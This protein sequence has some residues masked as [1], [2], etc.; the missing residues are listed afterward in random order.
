MLLKNNPH[1]CPFLTPCIF[2]IYLPISW[3]FHFGRKKPLPPLPF[4]TGKQERNTVIQSSCSWD[5]IDMTR[6]WTILSVSEQ[7]LG[8]LK[9]PFVRGLLK[10]YLSEYYFQA[11]WNSRL[12]QKSFNDN[13]WSVDW[14]LGNA[15]NPGN[16]LF[17]IHKADLRVLVIKKNRCQPWADAAYAPCAMPGALKEKPLM[18]KHQGLH[19]YHGCLFQ[20]PILSDW[21]KRPSL[22]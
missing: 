4:Y 10:I 20:H 14:W 2:Y 9:T 22:F 12:F 17:A 8:H 21:A 5:T 19:V 18:Q 11:A 6:P 7:G 13:I 1:L 3:H 15:L 16:L